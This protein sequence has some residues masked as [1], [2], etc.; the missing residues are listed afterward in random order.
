MSFRTLLLLLF[1]IDLQFKS[2]LYESL[3][4][5]P[6][7]KRCAICSGGGTRNPSWKEINTIILGPKLW[8]LTTHHGFATIIYTILSGKSLDPREKI[9]KPHEIFVLL[10][11]PKTCSKQQTV[12]ETL[13]RGPMYKST[14]TRFTFPSYSACDYANCNIIWF[15]MLSTSDTMLWSLLAGP[16]TSENTV[17]VFRYL[18]EQN[19]LCLY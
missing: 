10:Q 8:G 4:T 11:A 13:K 2:P 16:M 3:G 6:L 17:S 12:P 9:R 5:S 15:N 7:R 14:A 1:S 18:D 19:T